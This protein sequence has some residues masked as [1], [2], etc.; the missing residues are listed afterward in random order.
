MRNLDFCQFIHIPY[1]YH[2]QEI[3]SL[4]TKTYTVILKLYTI[5]IPL[6]EEGRFASNANTAFLVKGYCF[7]KS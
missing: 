4:C 7:Y 5:R 6:R 1:T 2:P 3:H